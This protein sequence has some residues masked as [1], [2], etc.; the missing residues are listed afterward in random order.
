MAIH[1]T[2]TGIEIDGKEAEKLSTFLTDKNINKQQII[3]SIKNMKKSLKLIKKYK[4]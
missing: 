1:Y 2:N 4:K 3:C